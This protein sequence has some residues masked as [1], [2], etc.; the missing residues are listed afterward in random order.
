M[1]KDGDG[2]KE[3]EKNFENDIKFSWTLF[4]ELIECLKIIDS[5]STY[6]YLQS[7]PHNPNSTALKS[8]KNHVS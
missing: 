1:S 6:W 7:F 3:Q 4:I 2:F 8:I 5:D